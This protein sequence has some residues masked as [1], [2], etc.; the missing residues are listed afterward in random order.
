MR[1]LIILSAA[2]GAV[3]FAACGDDAATTATPTAGPSGAATATIAPTPTPAPTLFTVGGSVAPAGPFV[4]L[5]Q[6][7]DY[8]VVPNPDAAPSGDFEFQ[9]SNAGPSVHELHLVK[10]DLAA[11][12]LPTDSNGAV[13]EEAREELHHDHHLGHVMDVA[14]GGQASF[15]ASLDAGHYVLFCNIV[16]QA[17]GGTIAH[18]TQGMRKDFTVE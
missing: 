10:T 18:Y 9:I 7:K 8:E 1:F 2:L 3:L 13:D 6:L 11:D 4:V 5:V 12:E 14:A 16:E 15:T 17:G